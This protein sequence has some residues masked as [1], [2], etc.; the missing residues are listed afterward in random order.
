MIQNIKGKKNIIKCIEQPQF[1]FSSLLFYIYSITGAMSKNNF[2]TKE[3]HALKIN[4]V[5]HK[6][7]A[8][9]YNL[10][11]FKFNWPF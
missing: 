9:T 6:I 8:K 10:Y 7:S 5:Y 2:C 11:H 1:S 3:M 4:V